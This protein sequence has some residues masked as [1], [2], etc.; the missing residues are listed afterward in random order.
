[1]ST[2]YGKVCVKRHVY[3][4]VCGGVCYVPADSTAG[5][6]G[7]S[8]PR[9]AKLLASDYCEGS[10]RK[11]S[12]R[13]KE[14]HEVEVSKD[15]VRDVSLRISRHAKEVESR[16]SYAMP[17]E[18]SLCGVSSV[19]ISRDGAMVHLLDGLPGKPKRKPGY[20][21]AM[22]GV[23][24]LYGHE[25]K[26]L[27]SIYLGVGAQEK[28]GAFTHLLEE[29][30]ER[31]KAQFEEAGLRPVYVGVADGAPDNWTQLERLTDYQVTDYYHVTERL[32]KL[33]AVMPLPSKKRAQWVSQQKSTLLNEPGG[34][35]LVVERAR[36][37]AAGV[38]TQKRREIARQQVVYLENQQHR[39]NYFQMQEKGLPIGSGTVEAGCKTLI[40]ARLG[41]S[42]MRWLNVHADDMLIV[43]ALKLSAG[44]YEQYWK[45]RMRYA[46]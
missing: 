26:L 10:A 39:M 18:V 33:A 36:Q 25:G 27:H 13:F 12:A 35:A 1:M 46:A 45:K 44:R 20:R 34:A 9:L 17:E 3:Q 37:A 11:V 21:E 43:R 15:L 38:K 8:T 40:K 24:S 6:V 14:H 2:P 19:S 42:G 22:C 30:A 5:I 16:W 29:E 7:K 32:Y 4:P 28:K 23:I 31:L 41:G